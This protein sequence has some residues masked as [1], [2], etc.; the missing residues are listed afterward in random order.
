M[1]ESALGLLLDCVEVVRHGEVERILLDQA[2]VLY[3]I[4][5][6][7]AGRLVLIKIDVTAYT[8]AGRLVRTCH[9]TVEMRL[10]DG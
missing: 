9:H 1:N 3:G 6:R 10:V 2:H 4:A 5:V 8:I 7:G